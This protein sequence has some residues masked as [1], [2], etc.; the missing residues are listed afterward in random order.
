[1]RRKNFIPI[2]ETQERPAGRFIQRISKHTKMN[3]EWH[4]RLID[5]MIHN[6]SDARI[7]DY[8]RIVDQEEENQHLANV[9]AIEGT[10]EVRNIPVK[11]VIEREEWLKNESMENIKAK[12][13]SD[14][15]RRGIYVGRTKKKKLRYEK[16]NALI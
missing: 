1:V 4:D 5:R 16:K 13:K 9:K 7:K 3:L 2:E 15:K 11:N 14:T 10:V 8:Y 12:I 6:N